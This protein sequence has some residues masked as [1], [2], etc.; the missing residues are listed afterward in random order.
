MS[1]F[2]WLVM[3]GNIAVVLGVLINVAPIMAWVERHLAA[4]Y[5]SGD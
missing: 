4:D 5:Q 3:A 2:D 1:T